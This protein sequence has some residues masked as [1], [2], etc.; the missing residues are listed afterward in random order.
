[1][2]LVMS[3]ASKLSMESR[4]QPSTLLNDA[5]HAHS[6]TRTHAQVLFNFSWGVGVGLTL[7][8]SFQLAMC[9]LTTQRDKIKGCWSGF[10]FTLKAKHCLWFMSPG[11]RR[12]LSTESDSRRDVGGFGLG[13]SPTTMSTRIPTRLLSLW[14]VSYIKVAQREMDTE[15]KKRDPQRVV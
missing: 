8:E 15:R 9:F 7:V 12:F 14:A 2:P 1:M 4:L 3:P 11:R 10:V 6:N 5:I 13:A